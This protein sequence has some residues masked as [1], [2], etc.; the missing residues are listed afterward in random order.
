MR[1]GVVMTLQTTRARYLNVNDLAE[2]YGVS[3]FTIYRWRSE[4]R[5]MP[6]AVKI[7]QAVRWREEEL[8]RWDAEHEGL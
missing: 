5:D 8:D 3:A 7:G 2:R 1:I 6:K 4:G